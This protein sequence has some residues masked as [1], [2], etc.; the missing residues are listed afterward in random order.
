[1]NSYG[2]R[3]RILLPIALL[4]VAACSSNGGTGG[5]DNAGGAGGALQHA[6]LGTV[7]VQGVTRDF[8]CDLA[9]AGVGLAY[10]P[11]G[12]I[13]MNCTLKNVVGEVRIG[14]D[15]PTSVGTHTR[16]DVDTGASLKTATAT[17]EGTA[18]S[19]DPI[20]FDTTVTS[21]DS[22]AKHGSGRSRAV[23]TSATPPDGFDVSFD[24]AL[25]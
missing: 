3:G 16:G 2:E 14:I 4:A 19:V 6:V 7:T 23:F 1:V 8:S 18:A 20:T 5:T 12:S 24:F 25:P 15:T 21:W 22:D 13:G 10:S 17:Y 9:G 11:A